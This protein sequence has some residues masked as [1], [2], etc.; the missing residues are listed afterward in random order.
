MK[1]FAS[2]GPKETRLVTLLVNAVH[3]RE[4]LKEAFAQLKA[5]NPRFSYATFARRSGIKSRSFLCDVIEGRK[6]L[7]PRS[8]P[9]VALGLG[10]S[11]SERDF[12]TLL[13]ARDEPDLF[14]SPSRA[15]ISN[16][17]ENLRLRLDPN[18]PALPAAERFFDNQL[19]PYVYAALGT[20]EEGR[21]VAD[22]ARILSVPVLVVQK[23]VEEMAQCDVVRF[24]RETGAVLPG[25]A[26]LMFAQA[27]RVF[28]FRH[29]WIENAKTHLK[30]AQANFAASDTLYFASAFSVDKA[31]LPKLRSALNE[32]LAQ[33]VDGAEN[34]RGETILTL[35]CGLVPRA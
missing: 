14:P 31:Q 24:H 4:F 7:S 1:S 32:V 15:E 18:V 33:F 6:R 25:K 21:T 29:F 30:R 20:P 8:I 34:P 10:L 23:T 19:W 26:H 12:F 13:V 28:E 9:S 17:M 11:S 16:R 27:G 35:T 5:A 22:L 2:D 3:Y